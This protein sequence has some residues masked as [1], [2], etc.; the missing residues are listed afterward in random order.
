MN[1]AHYPASVRTFVHYELLLPAT[2]LA[3]KYF[4]Q[5]LLKVCSP[6]ITGSQHN[7]TLVGGGVGSDERSRT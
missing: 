2:S 7:D 4:I 1:V 5:T 6:R 3:G